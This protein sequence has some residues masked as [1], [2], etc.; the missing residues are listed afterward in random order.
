MKTLFDIEERNEQI[1]RRLKA[2]RRSLKTKSL[3]QAEAS[4][5]A[6]EFSMLLSESE[7]LTSS[8]CHFREMAE[9]LMNCEC[10]GPH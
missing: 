4:N 6:E 9:Q 3:N 10:S 1:E 2:I 5:L 8:L 7:I